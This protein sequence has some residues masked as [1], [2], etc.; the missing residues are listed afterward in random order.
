M[1]RS[2]VR[3]AGYEWQSTFKEVYRMT[4]FFSKTISCESSLHT[5]LLR[6]RGPFFVFRSTIS[7]FEIFTISGFAIDVHVKLSI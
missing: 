4:P 6:S 7:A 1:T 5:Q 2:V 3:T